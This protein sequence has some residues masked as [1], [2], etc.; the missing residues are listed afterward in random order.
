[1]NRDTLRQIVNVI[2]FIVTL[3]VNYLSQVARLNGTTNGEIANTFDI[4]FFPANFTFSIWGVLYLLQLGF[5][6]YQALPSQRENPMLRRIGYGYAIGSLANI[7]WIFLFQ[8]YQFALSLVA[9]L[10]LLVS[11]IGIYSRLD[12][13]RTAFSTRDRWLVQIPF[14]AYLG[15]I[16]VATVANVTYV[17]DDAGWDGFGITGATWGAIMVVVATFVAGA[18]ILRN[19]DIAYALVILWAFY[20]IIARFP[21]TPV[22]TMTTIVMLVVVTIA[23]VFGVLMNRGGGITARRAA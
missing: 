13:G 23:A 4:Y 6:V 22:L 9:M 20:G 18:V 3:A 10:V 12:V 5:I 17:L 21:N 2:V 15:W 14:S 8:Y 19:R 7:A 11:L 16:T 1:M